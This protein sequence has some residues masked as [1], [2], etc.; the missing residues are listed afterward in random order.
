[1]VCLIPFSFLLY[2]Y[3]QSLTP[4]TLKVNAVF[5]TS[6]LKLFLAGRGSLCSHSCLPF[7]KLFSDPK[8]KGRKWFIQGLAQIQ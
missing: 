6:P 2:D 7:Q 1:M 5:N 8:V 4:K 3:A